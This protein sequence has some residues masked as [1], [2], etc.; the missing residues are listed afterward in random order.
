MRFFIFIF[1][2]I[3]FTANSL[4]ANEMLRIRAIVDDISDL[5]VDYEECQ[6]QLQLKNNTVPAFKAQK[7]DCSN[8]EK[9][10]EFMLQK[11]F[12]KLEETN[13]KNKELKKQITL[14][15]NKI[16]LQESV[17][18]T[19]DNLINELNSKTTNL[20]KKLV[21]VQRSKSKV[22]VIYKKSIE[23]KN[24]FPKLMMKEDSVVHL[25]TKE[26]I[27]SVQASSYRLI[28][29][30][31]IY[32]KINGEIIDSWSMATSFTSNKRSQNWVQITGYFINKKW[33][34]S[35]KSMWIKIDAVVQR[36]K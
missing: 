4:F 7:S 20:E 15:E 23:T 35:P 18:K 19:K 24:K 27:R 21:K 17:L 9:K 36:K 6:A 3:F 11:E 26:K 13:Y 8:T 34:P 5:R 30:A 2:F 25:N 1:I 10:Y 12:T 28:K 16:K 31:K 33:L 22:Q 14:L 32:N 29:D